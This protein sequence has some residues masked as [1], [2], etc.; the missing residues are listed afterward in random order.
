MPP[1]PVPTRHSQSGASGT[2]PAALRPPRRF[3]RAGAPLADRL[4]RRGCGCTDAR[5]C[6]RARLPSAAAAAAAVPAAQRGHPQARARA[7]GP[8]CRAQQRH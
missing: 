4:E 1:P 8:P 7:R 5:P 2:A 3:P 6:A